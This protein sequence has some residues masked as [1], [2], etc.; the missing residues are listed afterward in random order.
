MKNKQD[1]RRAT[2]FILAILILIIAV[3]VANAR[4]ERNY[5]NTASEHI[6]LVIDSIDFRTDL[7]RM[8][9]RLIGR[10]H[11]SQKIERIEMRAPAGD[12]EA[13]DIDGVDFNRWFQWEDDGVIAVEIDFKA[14]PAT[15]SGTLIVETARGVDTSKFSN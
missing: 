10:P 14:M 13:M 6:N 12:F 3:S 2:I 1:N 9:A 11:T 15:K 7:T 8:Y 4:V 5:K